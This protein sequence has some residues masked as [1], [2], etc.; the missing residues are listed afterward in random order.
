M[1][2]GYPAELSLTHR[3]GRK[4]RR[5]SE[6]CERLKHTR[7][8]NCLDLKDLYGRERWHSRKTKTWKLTTPF[9]KRTKAGTELLIWVVRTKCQL[10]GATIK[11][12]PSEKHQTRGHRGRGRGENVYLQSVRSGEQRARPEKTEMEGGGERGGREGGREG[13][14][15]RRLLL[16]QGEGSNLCRLTSKKVNTGIHM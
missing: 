4:H 3:G 7:S 2:A 16:F 5:Q 12:R 10:E 15:N 11:D 8:Y 14:G 1:R 6:F 13:G 9:A